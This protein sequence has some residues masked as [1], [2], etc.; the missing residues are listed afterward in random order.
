MTPIAPMRLEQVHH[1]CFN[2]QDASARVRV[3]AG[4]AEDTLLMFWRTESTT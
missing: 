1:G 4:Y 3:E 2:P